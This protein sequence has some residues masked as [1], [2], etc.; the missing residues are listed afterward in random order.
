MA[1]KPGSQFAPPSP[2][3]TRLLIWSLK[4]LLT[5]KGNK[6]PLSI[7]QKAKLFIAK[8]TLKK[9]LKDTPTEYLLITIQVINEIISKREKEEKNASKI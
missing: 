2:K 9:Q 1:I 4:S 5:E 3:D 6:M 8:N 7:T